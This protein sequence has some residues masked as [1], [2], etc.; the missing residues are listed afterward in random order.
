MKRTFKYKVKKINNETEYNCEQVLETCRQLWNIALEQRKIVLKQHKLLSLYDQQYQLKDLRA[1]F[2]Q[3]KNVNFQVLNNVL[4]RLDKSFKKFFS[5]KKKGLVKKGKGFPHFKKYNDYNSFTLT[6]NG[7]KINNDILSITNVGELK[8]FLY[9]PIEGKIKTI[10]IE[11]D[12]TDTWWVCFSCDEVPEKKKK[13]R[14]NFLYVKNKDKKTVGI[15]V[16]IKQ[17][18]VD[19]NN[20]YIENPKY[21]RKSQAKLSRLNKKL[22]R[23]KLYLFSIDRIQ[24]LKN[25]YKLSSDKFELINSIKDKHINSKEFGSIFKEFSLV[26]QNI[27]RKV[28]NNPSK[29]Y[30]KIKKM[31]AIKSLKIKNQ[32]E[33]FINTVANEYVEKFN[34]IS[35]EDLKITNMVRKGSS[36]K[37]GLN[38][39]INDSSWGLFFSKLAEKIKGTDKVLIKVDPKG[40][41]IECSVC[42]EKV[43]KKLNERVHKCPRCHIVLDRDLNASNNIDKRGKIV[44]FNKKNKKIKKSNYIQLNLFSKVDIPPLQSNSW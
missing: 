6:V 30:L 2:E 4:N 23:A 39:G 44:N 20:N 5:D 17:F 27:I 11:K 13:K 18:C 19:N 40:T 25:N 26:Q 29:N 36:N 34:Q 24:F 9:K 21:Y 32:R 1:E 16:G 14:N 22:S 3:F 10:T 15:D 31:I 37:K 33:I 8:L 7:W 41:T 38:K 28:F 43:Q 35:V 12:K 42:G